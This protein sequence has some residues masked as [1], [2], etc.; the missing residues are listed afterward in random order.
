MSKFNKLDS[1]ALL[2]IALSAVVISVWQVNLTRSHNE[3]TVN[4]TRTHNK[5]TVQPYIKFGSID[6]DDE[7]GNRVQFT[8]HNKGAGAALVKSFQIK[9][10]GEDY[11]TWQEAFSAAD[12]T[13]SIPQTTTMGAGI[14]VAPGETITMCT[15]SR[16]DPSYNYS[17]NFTIEFESLYQEVTR[18]SVTFNRTSN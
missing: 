11:D 15:I 9:M 4:L 14:I 6:L 8:V 17:L 2:I 10:N 13:I 16:D 3:L 7:E 5:L 18:E 1:Y 12:S